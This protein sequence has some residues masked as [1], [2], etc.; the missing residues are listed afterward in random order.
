MNHLD[1]FHR[2][3]IHFL[4]NKGPS[5]TNQVAVGLNISWATAKKK[6]MELLYMGYII[7]DNNK[8]WQVRKI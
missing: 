6:L 8:M 3:I 4:G 7:I 1:H 5:N 2:A